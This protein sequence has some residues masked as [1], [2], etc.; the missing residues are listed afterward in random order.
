MSSVADLPNDISALKA[1]VAERDAALADSAAT[2]SCKPLP[3]VTDRAQFAWFL[4][5]DACANRLICRPLA[6]RATC[7]VVIQLFAE[8]PAWTLP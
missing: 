8:N 5:A 6:A 1:F 2:A 7:K 3:P 4:F